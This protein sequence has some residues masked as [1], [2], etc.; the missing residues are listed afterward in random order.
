[1]NK[2]STEAESTIIAENF[3]KWALNEDTALP[4]TSNQIIARMT[5]DAVGLMYAA[6][7]EDYILSVTGSAI[8]KGFCWAVGHKTQLGS[9]DSCLVNGTAIHGEDFDDTYDCL[10]YTSPSPRDA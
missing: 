10:L 4:D 8:E 7:N 6:R 2:N 5:Y 3:A 9:Y 1:M